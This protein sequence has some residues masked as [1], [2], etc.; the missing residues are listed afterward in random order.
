V[1]CPPDTFRDRA[2]TGHA[3]ATALAALLSRRHVQFVD[4]YWPVELW[5]R[6]VQRPQ[7]ALDAPVHSLVRDSEFSV[8]LPNARVQPDVG[9]DGEIPLSERYRRV[10]EDRAR[11]V[12][13]RAAAILTQIPLKHPIAAV[14]NR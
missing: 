9:V 5:P 12:V 14:P 11:L 2:W 7:E 4:F 10:L 6:R 13:E 8:E 1:A 3:S